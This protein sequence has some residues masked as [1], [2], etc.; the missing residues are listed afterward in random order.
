MLES[1]NYIIGILI[2]ILFSLSN[3][4][5]SKII[6]LKNCIF[7]TFIYVFTMNFAN[8]YFILSALL[9]VIYFTICFILIHKLNIFQAYYYSL[10]IILFYLLSNIF[11]TYLLHPNQGYVIY[12]GD[13]DCIAVFISL[14]AFYYLDDLHFLNNKITKH[15]DDHVFII[16]MTFIFLIFICLLSY[17]AFVGKWNIYFFMIIL[18]FLILSIILIILLNYCYIYK[19]KDDLKMSTYKMNQ[20]N[21]V[22]YQS[23]EKDNE[24]L[25]KLKHDYKNHLLNIKQLVTLHKDEDVLEY[26][27]QLIDIKV[28]QEINHYCDISYI[29]SYLNSII[30]AYPQFD[31]DIHTTNLSHFKN[32]GLDLLIILMNLINNAIENASEKVISVDMVY[33]Q[34]LIIKVCNYTNSNPIKKRFISNK[35]KDHGLGL[36]IIDDII[37]KYNGESY[38]TFNDSLYAKYIILNLGEDYEEINL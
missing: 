33:D 8:D 35:G 2:G 9:K 20:L 4:N 32:I 3:Q 31:F 26:V 19:R 1:F 34:K 17:N 22:Y 11:L 38:D 14:L 23:L 6:I 16:L 36:K 24:T 18:G 37:S 25:R 10:I 30:H 28:L 29:D 12:S 21:Q 5:E 15:L 7:T 27:N 13:I